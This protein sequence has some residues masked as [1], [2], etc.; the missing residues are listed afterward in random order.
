MTRYIFATV[1]LVAVG[2]LAA[3]SAA[4]A[5]TDDDT[6][7]F[8]NS[9]ATFTA[10]TAL[11]ANTQYTFVFEAFNAAQSSTLDSKGIWIR[12]VDLTL[13]ANYIL[14]AEVDQPAAPMCLHPGEYCDHW[15]AWFDLVA[16]KIIWQSFGTIPT[17]EFG[18]VREQD[19]EPFMFL[20]TTD[21]VPTNWFAWRLWGD[22]GGPNGGNGSFVE[23]TATIGAVDDDTSYDDDSWYDDDAIGD[24]DIAIDDDL[25]FD[26]DAA[27]DDDI[28][29]DDDAASDD[30]AS[31]DDSGG[32]DSG[33]GD[34]GGCGG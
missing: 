26:D 31:D 21:D 29:S 5:D 25:G 17:I 23:G 2:I 11:V 18:D 27:G 10:P 14:A 4:R 15:E 7:S 19:T 28:A 34:H 33:S 32:D 22:D 3:A 6:A 8:Y 13:P 30:E 20:A 24:D 12:E 1:L 16:N 9:T